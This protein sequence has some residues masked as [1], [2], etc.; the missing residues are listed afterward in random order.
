MTAIFVGAAAGVLSGWGVGGGTLLLLYLTVFSHTPQAA[1]QGINL[2]YF[3]PCSALALVSHFK[4]RQVSMRAA[5]PAAA[6]GTVCTV[7][8]SLL[9]SSLDASLLKKL[10][11]GFLIAVGLLELFGKPKRGGQDKNEAQ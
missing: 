9:A 5:I 8:A 7:L 1:A 10:F 4:N 11:G 2:L 6:A 3:L